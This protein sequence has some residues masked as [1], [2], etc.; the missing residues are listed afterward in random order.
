MHLL[1]AIYFLRDIVRLTITKEDDMHRL[2]TIAENLI[3][4]V[5]TWKS[6]NSH[7]WLSFR[8]KELD[9]IAESC[10]DAMWKALEMDECEQWN[11]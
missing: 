5:G 11:Y 4:K 7:P 1:L 8:I 9:E 6:I 2:A 10:D 3:A